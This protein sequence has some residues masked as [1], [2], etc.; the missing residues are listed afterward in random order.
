MALTPNERRRLRE[1]EQ[2][3]ARDDPDFATS[4]SEPGPPPQ[5]P[6]GRRPLLWW[7]LAVLAGVTVAIVVGVVAGITY[8]AVLMLFMLAASAF[9]LR[10][11]GDQD[12]RLVQRTRSALT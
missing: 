9:Y 11:S 4:M 5:E 6:D 8:A 7:T 1:I 3:L 2:Q 12:N 10:G